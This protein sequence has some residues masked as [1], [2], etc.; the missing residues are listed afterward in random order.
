MKRWPGATFRPW[1]QLF[2]TG[3]SS[4]QGLLLSKLHI[5]PCTCCPRE[6]QRLLRTSQLIGETHFPF[7]CLIHQVV[8][9]AFVIVIVTRRVLKSLRCRHR[10]SHKWPLTQGIVPGELTPHLS[11]LVNSH[12]I[13]FFWWTLAPVTVLGELSP[14]VLFLVNSHPIYCPW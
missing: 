5:T 13:Y 1:W 4:R 10:A 6:G 3:N 12:H 8:K 9:L 11:F 7:R 14:Y 2:D